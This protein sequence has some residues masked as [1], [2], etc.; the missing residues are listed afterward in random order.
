MKILYR[1]CIVSHHCSSAIAASAPN[2]SSSPT[3]FDG[4]KTQ[5]SQSG[6]LY[7]FSIE[8]DYATPAALPWTS[9][10]LPD[11]SIIYIK[12]SNAAPDSFFGV[13]LALSSDGNTLVAGAPNDETRACGVGAGETTGVAFVPI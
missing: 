11:P 10:S 6:A 13:A 5:S 1:F 12:A 3:S 9:I 8:P 2:E 4:E 7:V